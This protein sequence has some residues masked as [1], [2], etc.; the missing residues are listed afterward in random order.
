MVFGQPYHLPIEL[1]HR[2]YWAVKQF[3]MRMDDVGAHRKL[4]LQE[5]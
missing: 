2:A 1:E 5:L 3:N 4:Q